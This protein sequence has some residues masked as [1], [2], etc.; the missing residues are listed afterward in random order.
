M[1]N[2]HLYLYPSRCTRHTHIQDSLEPEERD[3]KRFGNNNNNK[4]KVHGTLNRSKRSKTGCLALVGTQRR[5]VGQIWQ[6]SEASLGL[7][8]H[9]TL[10]RPPS[11]YPPLRVIQ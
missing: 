7:V 2:T 1:G 10:Q 5:L 4:K 11:V 9:I 6:L 8:T 3:M